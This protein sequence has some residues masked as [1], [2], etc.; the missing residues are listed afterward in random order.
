MNDGAKAQTNMKPV[1]KET[2]DEVMT[3]VAIPMAGMN[4]MR[5]S[6]QLAEKL[7]KLMQSMETNGNKDD[8]MEIDKEE[9]RKQTCVVQLPVD[10]TKVAPN[11][12]SAAPSL[13]VKKSRNN[14]TPMPHAKAKA[15]FNTLNK[16]IK[17]TDEQHN[18]N[19]LINQDNRDFAASQSTTKKQCQ[20][21]HRSREGINSNTPCASTRAHT[22]INHWTAGNK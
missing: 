12:P 7:K 19:A 18:H 6:A 21:H 1:N 16:H 22:N 3:E 10:L 13:E 4:P 8:M 11:S 14:K 9:Q 15:L 2:K 5:T 20:G 17:Q